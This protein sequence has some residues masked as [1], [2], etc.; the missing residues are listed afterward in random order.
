MVDIH[1]HILPHIDDGAKDTKTSVAMLNSLQQQGVNTVVLTPHYYGKRSSP[2][3]FI[4]RRNTIFER[5]KEEIPQGMQVRLGAEVHFTGMNMAEYEELCALGIEGTKYILIEFPFTSKW[6]HDLMEKLFDFIRET[7]YTP[8]IAHVERYTE[9]QKNPR[10]TSELAYMGCLLQ[11]NA[12]SFLDKR[13]SK[14][15]FA[16]LKHGLVH[17][18]GTD[19]HDMDRRSPKYA[20]AKQAVIEKGYGAEWLRAEE[21]T[22]DVLSGTHVRVESGKPIKKFLGKY[23]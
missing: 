11:V 1:T 20:E 9:V 16:L 3:E 4:K 22:K 7:E 8:I 12:P 2:T 13:E 18:I 23:F 19:A 15:A 10:L 5:L 6:N 14:L 21:I 17:C